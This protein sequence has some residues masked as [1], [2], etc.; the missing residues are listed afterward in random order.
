MN[1]KT[2]LIIAIFLLLFPV[3]AFAWN[4]LWY[5]THEALADDAIHVF[6]QAEYPDLYKFEEKLRD[7]SESESPHPGNIYNGGN[8]EDWWKEKALMSYK[9]FKFSGAYA[10][11]GEVAHL[12]QDQ[13]VPA[14]AANIKHGP[15]A[16]HLDN[17]EG[18]ADNN[19][20][21]N[22]TNG[23]S[24]SLPFQYYQP[25][26]NDT[27]AKLSTWKKSS[28]EQYW[29]PATNAPLDAT[30]G[31][32]TNAP[33]GSYGGAENNDVYDVK[34]DTQGIIASQVY[35]AARYTAGVFA[36]ASKNLPPLVK[37]LQITSSSNCNNV[38]TIGKQTS[39]QISFKILEN[40][41]KTVKIFITVDGEAIISSE[42]GTGKS[43]D[44]SSGSSLPWEGTYTIS[45]DGK[46]ASGQYPSDGE[47]S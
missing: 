27:R 3:S 44:L 45:W 33:W 14:H 18:D 13:A 16:L 10:Q 9:A 29:K 34:N 6:T 19:Y 25:L 24:Y 1:K 36:A 4:S 46:L 26:Q 12:T 32:Q 43:Y 17:F 20:V 47:Y 8:A 7:G 15:Y 40:R 35:M 39:A 37:D 42:Y 23:Y 21:K 11:I 38:P 30:G 28:T 41:K 31:D 22:P 5:Y 2:I